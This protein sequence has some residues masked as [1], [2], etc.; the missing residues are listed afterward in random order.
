MQAVRTRDPGSQQ[1]STPLLYLKGFPRFTAYRIAIG[2]GRGAT[3]AGHFPANGVGRPRWISTRRRR[4]AAHHARPRDRYCG[5]RNRG[6]RK[7]RLYPTVR[8]PRRY[9]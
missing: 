5:G 3:R 9:Q 1:I 7:R 8:D 2:C 4:L 6:Y